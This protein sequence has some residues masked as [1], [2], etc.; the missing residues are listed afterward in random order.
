MVE[1]E[2]LFSSG[3]GILVPMEDRESALRF[4]QRAME[5]EP[6]AKIGMFHLSTPYE[7]V[8]LDLA[9][10]SFIRPKKKNPP[11]LSTPLKLPA[12]SSFKEEGE[13][14]SGHYASRNEHEEAIRH[15]RDAESSGEPR[16]F[17]VDAD[18]NVKTQVTDSYGRAE[19]RLRQAEARMDAIDTQRRKVEADLRK[20]AEDLEDAVKESELK[21]KMEHLEIDH[22]IQ[23]MKDKE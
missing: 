8:L 10:I 21:K 3:Q 9:D 16:T 18:G 14:V 22:E 6:D 23:R 17:M 1:L 2:I 5:Y 15:R 4:M 11:R 19:E 20:T 7:E 12:H 13:A